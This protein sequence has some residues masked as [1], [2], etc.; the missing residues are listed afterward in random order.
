MLLKNKKGFSLIELLIVLAIVGL[1]APLLFVVFVSGIEDYSTTTKYLDQQY[2]VIE[3]T[4]LIR[5]D[6]EESKTITFT[7]DATTGEITAIKF[8]FPPNTIGSTTVAR[9]SKEWKFAT[10]TDSGKDYDGLGLDVGATGH[11]TLVIDDLDLTNSKFELDGTRLILTIKPKQLNMTKYRGR[12]V[13]ENII[14]EFSVR[15]KE[16]K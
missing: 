2:T 10:F 15:Y 13:N 6:V 16:I 12:N 14:T 11:S 7:K 9:A 5:Q 3:V 4:R 8:E 1:M